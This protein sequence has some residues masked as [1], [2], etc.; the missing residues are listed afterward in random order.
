[1]MAPIFKDEAANG[2]LQSVFGVVSDTL[3]TPR[4]V[5]EMLGVPISWVYERTVVT[6]PRGCLISRSVN[7]FAFAKRIFLDGWTSTGYNSRRREKL[8]SRKRRSNAKT[9]SARLSF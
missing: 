8:A 6:E 2:T 9:F 7:I 5:A 1:M 3:L 4:E